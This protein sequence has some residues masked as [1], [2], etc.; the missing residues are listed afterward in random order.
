MS[1]CSKCKKSLEEIN[2]TWRRVDGKL[3]L[4]CEECNE[5]SNKTIPKPSDTI[6]KSSE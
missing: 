5:K 6:R 2:L 4:L 3:L 1:R